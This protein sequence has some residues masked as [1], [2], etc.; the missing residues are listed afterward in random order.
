MKTNLYLV[1]LTLILFYGCSASKDEIKTSGSEYPSELKVI[2]REQWGWKPEEKTLP[3]HTINKITLHHGGEYFAEDKD[4][5]AYL[6]NLQSWSRSEK[7]WMDI[8]YHYMIDLKGNIYETRPLKYPGDTNTDYDVR[9][10]A[11]ICVM[12]NYE[13]QKFNKEQM[14]AVVDL[15]SFLVKKY[16]VNLDSIKGHKD[17]ALTLCPGE[18]FYRFIR[19][20]TIQKLVAQK[21]AGMEINYDEI[22][23]TGPVVK[24]GIEVLRDSNFDI[25]KGKRVGL[26]TN[27]TGV[28]SK[29]KSTID[30]L[31]ESPD[32]NL[33]ALFGPEHG[34]RGNYAGG[35]YVD[36]YI[37]EYTKLPVYSLYGKT[38]KPDSTMLKNIDVLIYDI[39]DIGCRS[40]TY[41]STMG[42]VMEAASENNIE[43]VVLD[44]PNPLGGN[45]VEGGLVEEGHFTFVSMFKI[46]YVY[47]L[48][49]GELAKLINEEGMLRGGVKC[50]L[51]VVP[52]EGWN[53]G[54]TFEETGLPWVP[55]SP[56]IPDVYSPFYYVASGIVGELYAISIGVGYT[57]PFQTFAAEWFDSKKLADKMNSYGMDGVIFRPITY[58]PFYSFGMGKDLGGVEIHITDYK[59]AKLMPIQ[60]YFLHA[61]KE[62][63]PDSTLFKNE[64]KSRFKMFDNVIGNDRVREILSRNFSMNELK[65]YFEKDAS[66]FR[67]FSKKYFLYK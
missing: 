13:V 37:D 14:K 29:L 39:Q 48:T 63:Y 30:I 43:V 51:T 50:K 23:N 66:E 36:F 52:M 1:T 60:F 35:D 18:D 33:V 61:L 31:H 54:M 44:R 28:D 15:T 9:G 40:Y 38:R 17:Y 56:H 67:E 16:N 46:P 24:T 62:L 25:L 64:N 6:R 32:V 65:E 58:K 8:P 59:N 34:V 12:G 2:T 27:P 49:C 11:L 53:R 42:L 19:D 5:T 20:H 26:V 41:I 3:E 21:L 55:T 7:K 4:V 47:G 45:R 22:F 57:L 10:H